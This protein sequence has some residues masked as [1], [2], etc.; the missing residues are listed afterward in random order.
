MQLHLRLGRA[1]IKLSH[2]ASLAGRIFG[3]VYDYIQRLF[4]FDSGACPLRRCYHGFH[5]FSGAR[6]H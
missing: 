5:S 3:G 2:G 6:G 1:E 4:L